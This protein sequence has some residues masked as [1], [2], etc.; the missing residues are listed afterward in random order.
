LESGSSATH[1]DDVFSQLSD[2]IRQHMSGEL[3]ERALSGRALSGRELSGRALSG[4]ALSARALPARESSEKTSELPTSER[5]YGDTNQL[6]N[7]TPAQ[8]VTKAPPATNA[9]GDEHEAYMRPAPR[10][11][12]TEM[13]ATEP[14]L[15]SATASIHSMRS[16]YGL[17]G[18]R[19]IEIPRGGP[20]MQMDYREMSEA[21]IRSD[22]EG[23][24]ETTRS[25]SQVQLLHGHNRPSQDSY[26]NTS[27]Y[28]E[29]N[30]LSAMSDTLAAGLQSSRPYRAAPRTNTDVDDVERAKV[31][32][33]RMYKHKV[34]EQD[35]RANYSGNVLP[36][37]RSPY[38][39][40]FQVFQEENGRRTSV[41]TRARNNDIELEEIRRRNP[42][43]VRLA[44]DQVYAENASPSEQPRRVPR[45]VT[46][47]ERL[48]A[49]RGVFSPRHRLVLANQRIINDAIAEDMDTSESSRNLLARTPTLDDH[50]TRLEFSE[51]VNTFR[52]FRDI[53]RTPTPSDNHSRSGLD[54]GERP[55][56]PIFPAT[57]YSPIENRGNLAPFAPE[58]RAHER[59]RGQP[60]HA[61]RAAMSSQTSLRALI[62]SGSPTSNIQG[63]FTDREMAEASNRWDPF[64]RRENYNRRHHGR[65][66]SARYPEFVSSPAQRSDT[67]GRMLVTPSEALDPEMQVLQTEVS[68]RYLMR[69]LACP[70]LCMAYYWGYCDY[71]MAKQT[72]GRIKVMSRS[73][74]EEAFAW[75]AVTSI[76]YAL[77]IVGIVTAAIITKQK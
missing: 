58:P 17:P 63:A 14:G 30:R 61:R 76:L 74:K 1:S 51:S 39:T 32:M 33:S 31:A 2:D 4:R 48:S 40:D 19:S 11:S 67:Q 8:R 25:E 29:S 73:K 47:M 43:A 60:R 69:I 44:A 36:G 53:G 20:H 5:T 50:D 10:L 54:L 26:A 41:Q 62:T 72:D 9:P 3:S 64:P 75:A 49:V 34:L 45:A 12:A 15:Q 16:Q 57:V 55:V 71:L 13:T 27:T 59:V 37:S 28:E 35:T 24:W 65:N 66:A 52:T 46:P 56:T 21:T 6:L 7:L 68:H 22:T 18:S 70:P 38:A 77:I 42:S 23:D